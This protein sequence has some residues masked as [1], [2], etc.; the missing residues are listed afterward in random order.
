MAAKNKV[1]EEST[2]EIV[3]LDDAVKLIKRKVMADLEPTMDVVRKLKEASEGAAKA[4]DVV[5]LQAIVQ[6]LQNVPAPEQIDLGQLREELKAEIMAEIRPLIKLETQAT[7]RE[8]LQRFGVKPATLDSGDMNAIIGELIPLLM[9]A[10]MGSGGLGALASKHLP[11]PETEEI[12]SKPELSEAERRDLQTKCQTCGA[13]LRVKGSYNECAKCGAPNYAYRCYACKEVFLTIL[14]P[15]EI[16]G[17]DCPLCNAPVK[18]LK[19]R[20]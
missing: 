5:A 18:S 3:D 12:Q 16:G 9:P 15:D 10:V 19:A 8:V 14:S 7:F 20:R 1:D 2:E 17:T 4:T 11:Q 13:P 6:E